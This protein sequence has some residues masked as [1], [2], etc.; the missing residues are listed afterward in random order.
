MALS[1][2]NLKNKIKVIPK[3]YLKN[4]NKPLSLEERIKILEE[5]KNKFEAQKK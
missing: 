3:R 2:S 4:E 1:Q 5:W